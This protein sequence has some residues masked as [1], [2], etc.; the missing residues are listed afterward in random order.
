M[1]RSKERPQQP[2][3]Q[4]FVGKLRAVEKQASPLETF[5]NKFPYASLKI[6]AGIHRS[7]VINAASERII[8]DVNKDPS[9]F[10]ISLLPYHHWADEGKNTLK[11][12]IPFAEMIIERG[13]GNI[14]TKGLW[15]EALPQRVRET[16]S[17]AV[18]AVLALPNI[19]E[20]VRKKL[21]QNEKI[22]DLEGS[23]PNVQSE[24][25]RQFFA[26]IKE[27]QKLLNPKETTAGIDER[28]EEVLTDSDLTGILVTS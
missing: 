17:L 8:I 6:G 18:E 25:S 10:T 7:L 27:L 2:S 3:H 15:H 22:I 13:T 9:I 5:F 11:G 19:P 20:K 14:E 16:T 28:K 26:K 23:I 1:F 21:T 12:G 4:G 24:T